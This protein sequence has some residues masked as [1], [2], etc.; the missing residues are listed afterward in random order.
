MY[1]IEMGSIDY[2]VYRGGFTET[3][4]DG[5]FMTSE[6]HTTV[7]ISNE[8][9]E[10]IAEIAREHDLESMPDAI[11][12]AVDVTRDLETTSDPE[13]EELSDSEFADEILSISDTE[14]F[15]Q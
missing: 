1:R 5:A 7:T 14:N 4:Y 3:K 15:S 2:I 8:T 13:L 11:D 10:K 9:A 6:E 12:Y